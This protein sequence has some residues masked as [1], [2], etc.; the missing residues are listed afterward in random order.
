MIKAAYRRR[1]GKHAGSRC[2]AAAIGFHLRHRNIAS[3]KPTRLQGQFHLV[4]IEDTIARQRRDR[5]SNR[6]GPLHCQPLTK[7]LVEFRML[8]EVRS[9]RSYRLAAA[10]LSFCHAVRMGS[11]VLK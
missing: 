5:R 8:D 10:V 1:A 4:E 6:P 11:R 3:P 7:T 9:E 2:P